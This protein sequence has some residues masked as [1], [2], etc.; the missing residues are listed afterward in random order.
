MSS[1]TNHF[2][3]I[4][5]VRW[6]SSAF[7][8]CTWA[9]QF[10]F[11]KLYKYFS[12]KIILLLQ[13]WWS[14]VCGIAGNNLG[15]FSRWCIDPVFGMEVVLL[16]IQSHP[17]IFRC[18]RPARS[19]P[20]FLWIK[21]PYPWVINE[22]PALAF[23][24]SKKHWRRGFT[25]LSVKRSERLT[26][27]TISYLSHPW[28]CCSL[29]FLGP[30]QHTLGQMGKWLR[31]SL[32]LLF[33]SLH[34]SSINTNAETRQLSLYVLSRTEMSLPVSSSR[35]A[36]TRRQMFWNGTYR[37]IIKSFNLMYYFLSSTSQVFPLS[38]LSVDNSS[39]LPVALAGM[40]MVGWW[41]VFWSNG[42]RL[43]KS[44]YKENL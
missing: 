11:A 9:F 37:R 25:S 22:D 29:A 26:S 18:R 15:A 28:Q 32:F 34:F 31:Y 8:L 38:L 2:H 23:L 36:L 35:R 39:R 14:Q 12:I 13:V 5:D 44:N 21:S 7:R 41:G 10:G 4:A 42:A 27:S 33:S 1:I 40:T 30:E 19:Y 3:T 17:Q 20:T 16:V 6:Y 43:N 24:R